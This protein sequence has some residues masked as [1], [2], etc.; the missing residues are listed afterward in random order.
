MDAAVELERLLGPDRVRTHPLDRW[1]FSKDAGISRGD[2]EVIVFPETTDEVAACVRIARRF[3]LTIVARGA[4]TGLAGGAVPSGSSLVVVLTR[5]NRIWEVDD[6]GRTAWVGPGVINL[7]L[8]M[9][10][11]D[12]GVHFAPDPSSQQSCTIGGNVGTNAG[13][14][15]CLTD[16]TT[17]AHVLGVEMVTADGAVVILGGEAPDVPGLDLRAVVIGSEGTVGIVTRV[18]VKL[19]ENAPSV[20]T[21]LLSFDAIEDAAATVSG[22]ISRGL[23]P[24]ALEMMDRPM[25]VAVE[26]F[27][28]AGYP[29]EA[30][31][32]LLAE[33]VGLPAGCRAEA[34]IIRS[35]AEANGATGVRIARDDAERTLLWKGRKSAFG[36]VAQSAP[37]YY[38]HDTVVPRTR[39][40]EVLRAVYEIAERYK[41]NLLN[42]FHA[43]DGNFHPLMSF[44][45][46]VPGT[47]DRVMAASDEMV[48]VAV[49]A[50][51]TLSGEHGIG[52]EKRDLMPLVFNEV[53]LDAQARLREAFDPDGALN[54]GKVLPRGSRCFDGF[55]ARSGPGAA[56]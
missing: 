37:D 44:D 20:V 11:A 15:H 49:A 53:D 34:E 8:S 13:G 3:E 16:G 9:E 52:L 31:A 10:L 17:T 30:A 21:L 6:V 35:V 50:G 5:M 43:G 38:L 39:L 7:D 12:R 46:S 22:V 2:T 36:A 41:L 29:T 19:T 14:P 47:M 54:P 27:V 40:V 18:L 23:V 45:V 26:N 33:V 25:V 28:H 56:S 24:A 51:G 4:G 1:L 32:V 48:R 55:S 42:V